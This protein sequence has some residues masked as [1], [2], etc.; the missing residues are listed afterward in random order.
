ALVWL[1]LADDWTEHVESWTATESGT[2]LHTNTPYYVRVTRDG[3][4]EAGHLRTLANNGPTLDER[5]IID[6]GFLELVRLGVKPHDDEVILNSI[7]VAD[8]TIRVDTPHGPAFYRYNGDGYGEREG[9]DEGAPWSIETKGSGRLWPIFTGE[10][11]EYEL[12]AGTE[13]GPLAPRNLLRTMQGFANSGRMLAEQVWDREHETDYNWEF[14]EGTGAAT[15]LAWSMAQ[16]C[17]LAHG[18]DADAPI[19]MPAFVRERYVETDRPDGP[20]LRVNTNFAGDELVVDGETDGVLVAVRTEQS[21]A[22][23]E[24]EDGEFETRIG[25]GYGENQVTVA[26][27]THADLTKAGT[28][29]K[30]FT[31]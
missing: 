12:V 10:R 22:L 18:I 1:A 20:S 15:P 13:E 16:Y 4:P 19:E 29:V 3:D 14:G 9:D 17:R 30:R 7:E 24:P 6:G 2:E 27:A 5:E 25:I 11:G 8:D 23:V 31:L 26:A 21:T 28:S